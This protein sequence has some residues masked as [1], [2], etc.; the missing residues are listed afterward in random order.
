[1]AVTQEKD[2]FVLSIHLKIR[3]VLHY[4]KIKGGEEFRAAKRSHRGDRFERRAPFLRCHALFVQQ[5]L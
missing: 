2:V 1:M 3:V 5:Y 4:L